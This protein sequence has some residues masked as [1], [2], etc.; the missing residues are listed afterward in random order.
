[1]DKT[2]FN[3]FFIQFLPIF[4]GYFFLKCSPIVGHF[5]VNL[6]LYFHSDLV[7]FC[8]YVPDKCTCLWLYFSCL[9]GHLQCLVLVCA[10]CYLPYSY[11]SHRSTFICNSISIIRY[12]NLYKLMYITNKESYQMNELYI[13]D[14]YVFTTIKS[15]GL[16]ALPRNKCD[17]VNSKK[18]I[19]L[20]T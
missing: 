17:K 2:I 14:I 10:N 13:F 20:L 5:N 7:K 18:V 11:I 3:A 16:S 12:L 19:H 6:V 4:V 9:V 8:I 15:L 1:M